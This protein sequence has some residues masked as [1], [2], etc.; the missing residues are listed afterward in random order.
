MQNTTITKMLEFDAGHR[1]LGHGGKCR[2]L[3]GHRYKAEI[4]VE[5]WKLNELDMVI[6]FGDVKR[7]V[8]A[9]IDKHWDHNF[10]CHPEDPL[11]DILVSDS[12]F[13]QLV[14]EASRKLNPQ[15]E[16]IF[17]A[18]EPY[19][20][21]NGNPTAENMAAVLFKEA[22]SMLRD[23]RINVLGVRLYE[24]PTCFAEV[25]RSI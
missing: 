23:N 9:W 1:V 21:P 18:R 5:A 10:I 16:R 14:S 19:I 20:M 22:D 17:G 6:D 12:A 11:L 3:H 15:A 24:T 7:L 8:G 25:L 2:F 4:T 13:A